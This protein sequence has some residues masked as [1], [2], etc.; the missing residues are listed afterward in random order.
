MFG[1]CIGTMALIIVLSVFNGF[2]NLV[3][4]LYNDFYSDLVIEPAS[5]KIL[6]IS[7]VD[8]TEIK[9]IK[10][11]VNF[12]EVVEE[13]VLLR[14]GD[15]QHIAILKGVSDDFLKRSKVD[16]AIIEGGFFLQKNQLEFA[17]IGVR[18]TSVACLPVWDSTYI[19]HTTLSP[20]VD[21]CPH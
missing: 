15:K 12:V 3:T 10:G 4:S 19:R 7:E 13:N 6:N 16:S 9:N 21:V 18:G 17:M 5:G 2:E 11:V 14:Q 8:M 1:V 20:E